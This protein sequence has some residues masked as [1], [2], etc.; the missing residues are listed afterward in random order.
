MHCDYG[1]CVREK[2][3]ITRKKGQLCVIVT[4]LTVV[5]TV[6]YICISNHSCCIPETN[7]MLNQLYLNVFKKLVLKVPLDTHTQ[8][9]MN[10]MKGGYAG[11]KVDV[12]LSPISDEPHAY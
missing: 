9:L 2:I 7:T 3:I 11:I 6:Q 1:L 8:S 4:K 12:G 5:I 10:S